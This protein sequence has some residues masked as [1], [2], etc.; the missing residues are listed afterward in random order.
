MNSFLLQQNI[1]EMPF[2]TFKQDASCYGYGP[3]VNASNLTSHDIASANA[4]LAPQRQRRLQDGSLKTTRDD[5]RHHAPKSTRRAL[6]PKYLSWTE[7]ELAKAVVARRIKSG[8]EVAEMY[9]DS[10]QSQ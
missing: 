2:L 9:V 1:S 5:A 7:R 3:G 6:M 10:L 4:R 8:K